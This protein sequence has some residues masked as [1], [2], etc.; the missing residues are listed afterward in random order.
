MRG[1]VTIRYN[2]ALR[3]LVEVKNRATRRATLGR[4]GATPEEVEF[5]TPYDGDCRRVEL[6]AMTSRQLVDFVE[7]ALARYGVAKVIPDDEVLNSGS[8]SSNSP[9]FCARPAGS[10]AA[11]DC[12]AIAAARRASNCSLSLLAMQ[13]RACCFRASVPIVLIDVVA[14]VVQVISRSRSQVV[15]LLGPDPPASHC[16]APHTSDA[17]PARRVAVPP[18]NQDRSA[19]SAFAP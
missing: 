15:T 19:A 3:V 2:T 1:R 12:L 8:A 6:N 14:A 17:V 9:T 4:H 5:L 10:F 18:H 16:H 7:A 11:A 13:W